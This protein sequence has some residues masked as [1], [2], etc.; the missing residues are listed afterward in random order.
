MQS[1]TP[2][3][4]ALLRVTGSKIWFP[5]HNSLHNAISPA[6]NCQDNLYQSRGESP[7]SLSGYSSARQGKTRRGDN[8]YFPSGKATDTSAASLSHLDWR[9]GGKEMFRG[10]GDRRRIRIILLLGA[11][12]RT[13]CVCAY[14]ALSSNLCSLNLTESIKE[15]GLF[16]LLCRS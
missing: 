3:I 10:N 13:F 2:F 11:R 1:H 9:Q 16:G 7:E 6:L 14:N 15:P 5:P 12:H 4:F 8:T